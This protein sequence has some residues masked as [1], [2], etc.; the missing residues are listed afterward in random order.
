M[1]KLTRKQLLEVRRQAKQT[2]ET[3]LED[4]R[5]T[6]PELAEE[7]EKKNIQRKDKLGFTREDR[8]NIAQ[9]KSTLEKSNPKITWNFEV[10]DLVH[11]PCG[12][13]GLIVENNAVDLEA[14]YYEHDMKK[15]LANNRYAGQVFVVTAIG[16][17]WYYPKQLKIVR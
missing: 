15:T 14:V 9:R 3:L 17:N 4:I 11:L 1:A 16:N 13:I 10:G 6:N 7:Q 2:R 12:S 8:Q 5:D